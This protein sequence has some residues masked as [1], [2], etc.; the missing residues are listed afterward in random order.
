[1]TLKTNILYKPCLLNYSAESLSLDT[2]NWN[3]H[4]VFVHLQFCPLLRNLSLIF[5]QLFLSSLAPAA[6]PATVSILFRCIVAAE[7][8]K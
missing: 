7:Y 6:Y 8:D 3:Q 5:I 4:F 2:I 1:M